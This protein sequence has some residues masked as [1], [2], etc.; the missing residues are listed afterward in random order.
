MVKNQEH[1]F[2]AY[3][4]INGDQNKIMDNEIG[5]DIIKNKI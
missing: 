4:I 2:K 1:L 5:E 3:D